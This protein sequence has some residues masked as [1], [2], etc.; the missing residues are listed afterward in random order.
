[1]RGE[2]YSNATREAAPTFIDV[3]AGCGGL[4]L[5]L[6][7]AGFRGLFAVEKS[8]LAFETFRSNLVD[9][10]GLYFQWPRWLPRQ[11]MPVH[12]LLRI[13]R[14][15]LAGLKG[16]V[17]L[18]AGGPPCQGFSLAGRRDPA[19]PRNVLTTDYIRLIK[20]L[21]PRLLLLENVFGYGVVFKARGSHARAMAHS[22]VPYSEVV[23][24]RL[25]R[26][27]YE[28]FS[29]I[30]CA[31]SYGVPQRRRRF[32]MLG[33]RLGDPILDQLDQETFEDLVRA[34][35]P[36]FR[37]AIGLSP[38]RDTTVREAIGDLCVRGKALIPCEDSPIP[39]YEQLKYAAPAIMSRYL[40][41]MRSNLGEIAPNSMR[42]AKHRK[43]T[44]AHFKRIQ[45]LCRPGV[46]LSDAEREKL[47]IKKLTI[48][49][50]SPHTIS[51]T[52]TTLP[53]DILH[54]SEPRI[55][56]VRELARLQ[57]FP[58]WFAFQGKY[59]TGGPERKHQCPRYT[60]AGNA[61]PPMLA[62]GLGRL[63]RDL[64]SGIMTSTL[65]SL[66]RDQFAARA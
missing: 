16:R 28:V 4:S 42:L 8:P 35:G 50:L 29:T 19:D 22:K 65:Q 45:R 51:S 41:I 55:L 31:S 37:R 57:S 32:I 66:S 56:T 27:G 1:M 2:I 17:D 25:R 44:I 49:V 26:A 18:V 3:F 61:V 5:G 48:T 63:V 54:Y 38:D 10:G 12:D 15:E 43:G 21:E 60:Q 11:A 7:R 13:Y 30:V 62:E 34:Y 9:G 36:T 40:E 39:G 24:R 20:E 47:G 59:T 6:G 64:A 23:R 33:V 53:E 46:S 14:A 52:V 58:D